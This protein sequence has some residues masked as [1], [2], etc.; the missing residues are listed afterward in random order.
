MGCPIDAFE[1]CH[2][3]TPLSDIREYDLLYSTYLE[4]HVKC[5]QE[6]EGSLNGMPFLIEVIHMIDYPM[7][8]G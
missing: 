8:R 4:W 1:S 2:G 3:T 7:K 6:G 5:P